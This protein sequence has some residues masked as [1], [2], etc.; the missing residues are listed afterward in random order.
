VLTESRGSSVGIATDYGPNSQRIRVRPQR[1][2]PAHYPN[3]AGVKR[4][5]RE[6]DH[7][8]PSITEVAND[9]AGL[10]RENP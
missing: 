1:P 2:D 7:S 10:Q 4:Q 8:P 6:A 5:G 9:G 3:D